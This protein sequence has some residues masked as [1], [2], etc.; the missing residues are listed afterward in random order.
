MF[1]ECKSLTS[2]DLSNFNTEKV[3]YMAGM[4]YC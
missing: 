1:Y 4:F 2:I 3:E